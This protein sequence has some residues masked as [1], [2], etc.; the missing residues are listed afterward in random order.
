[1]AL[2]AAVRAGL[3]IAPLGRMIGAELIAPLDLPDLPPLPASQIVM[4]A[5]TPTQ[6]LAAAAR[7]LAAS[8]RDTLRRAAS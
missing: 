3:G 2:V 5:R 4:L 1:M 8:V 7:A 6:D